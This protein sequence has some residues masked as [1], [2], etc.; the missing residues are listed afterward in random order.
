MLFLMFNMFFNAGT[1]VNLTFWRKKILSLSIIS[2]VIKQTITDHFDLNDCPLTG[3]TLLD[4]SV[5]SV[6]FWNTCW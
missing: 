5:S 6:A 2:N 1:H 3:E 4:L